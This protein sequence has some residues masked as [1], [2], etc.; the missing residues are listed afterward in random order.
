MDGENCIVDAGM[1]MLSADLNKIAQQLDTNNNY[2]VLEIHADHFETM[3]FEQIQNVVREHRI[4]TSDCQAY[5]DPKIGN[6]YLVFRLKPQ[7][8]PISFESLYFDLPPGVEFHSF[9]RSPVNSPRA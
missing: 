4:S 2:L 5:C 9:H 6:W 3:P 7:A 1:I 8:E